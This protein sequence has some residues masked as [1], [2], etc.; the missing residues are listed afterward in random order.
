MHRSAAVS[1]SCHESSKLT[2]PC[3]GGRAPQHFTPSFS[4]QMISVLPWFSLSL[5]G[6]SAD[7]LLGISTRSR[8]ESESLY[9]ILSTCTSCKTQHLWPKPSGAVVCGHRHNYLEDNLIGILFPFSK[10]TMVVFLLEPMIS[11]A[12][13]FWPG[14]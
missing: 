10:I 6:Y 12:M 1:C 8:H 13:H 3:L 2:I 7:G 9:S 14:L 4:S 11:L 5:G